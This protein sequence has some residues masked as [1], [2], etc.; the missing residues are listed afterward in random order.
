MFKEEQKD[1]NEFEKKR[2]QNLFR[3]L[4][5]DPQ[6]VIFGNQSITRQI[7]KK[8]TKS[9]Y[10]KD[11]VFN[12][13]YQNLEDKNFDK[14]NYKIPLTT[15]FYEKR[16]EIDRTTLYSIEKP[17][18]RVHA[19][20]ADLRFF[21]KS[22]VD[23]KYALLCVDLFTSKIYVYPMK[24]RSLLAKKLK[25]FYE[26][27]EQK[28]N[29][30][31]YLQTDLEF[32]QNAIKNLNK[33]F[34]VEMFHTKLRGG[35]A[36]AAEQ[37]IREFKKLLLK[38]KHL[39]KGDRKRLKPLKVIKNVVENLNKTPSPKYEIPP[40]T[41]EK[42]TLN[43]EFNREMFDFLR[44]KKV[45]N[46]KFRNEK[47]NRRKDRR[48]KKLRNPLNLDEKV[49]VL[50]ERLKKKD[51]PSKLFKATTENTPFY[52]REKIFTIYKRAKLYNGNYLYWIEDENNNKIEGRF[53]RDE[54]FALKNQFEE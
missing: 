44:V 18:Q 13:L 1:N 29:E 47:Y 32:K 35:K 42:S 22:A 21:A 8:L 41:V 37:K 17:F 11:K 51:A 10:E 36:F 27:I 34:N 43:S 7:Q 14:Q 49:L 16:S 54:L 2:I 3:T 25:L 31:M 23:P 39:T 48:Q 38:T 12:K 5:K 9:Y 6:S 19:D 50:A 33:E 53:V 24:N 30:K 52:N 4:Q 40:E 26:E 45:D 15:P 46:N 28:R 20:I